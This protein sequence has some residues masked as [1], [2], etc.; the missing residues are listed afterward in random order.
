MFRRWFAFLTSTLAGGSGPPG[1][2]P[3]A[4]TLSN[5][6]ASGD[7]TDGFT[8][9]VDTDQSGG[10]LFW[11][12]TTS[13]SAPTATQI[14]NGQDHTGSAAAWDG[15]Q[16][17]VGSGEQALALSSGLIGGTA[18]WLHVVHRDGDGLDS[19]IVTAGFTTDDAGG[20]D[21]TASY[22]VIGAI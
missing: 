5:L 11:V 4:P 14:R 17:V 7:G 19:N 12:V 18:Y 8:A 10:D 15:E 20:D 9:T 22:L 2:I 13:A 6:V 1:G 3:G 16:A 21:F